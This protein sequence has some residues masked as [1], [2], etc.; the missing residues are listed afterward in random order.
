M[1]LCLAPYGETDIHCTDTLGHPGDHTADS[2]AWERFIHHPSCPA[3]RLVDAGG[4]YLDKACLCGPEA[5]AE[6][7]VILAER[8]PDTMLLDVVAHADAATTELRA[9]WTQGPVGRRLAQALGL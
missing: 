6:D 3:R 7:A 5:A 8:T 9:G 4:P 2:F 1:N